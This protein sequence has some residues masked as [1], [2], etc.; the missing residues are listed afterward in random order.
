MKND[1]LYSLWADKYIGSH[2]L[3]SRERSR[4][5]EVACFLTM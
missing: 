1:E 4:A 5:V 3:G 2:I